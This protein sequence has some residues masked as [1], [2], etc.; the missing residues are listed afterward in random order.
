MAP[1]FANPTPPPSR[2]VIGARRRRIAKLERDP[3]MMAAVREALESERLGQGVRFEE[4]KR[5]N[6]DPSL[7][8]PEGEG[9][10]T[11][12]EGQL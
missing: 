12:G 8:A 3:V 2:R 10:R 6:T 7:S 1:N 9:G 5:R 11:P 4:L